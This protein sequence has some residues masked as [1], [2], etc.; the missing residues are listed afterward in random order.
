[1][2]TY[3]IPVEETFSF[4]RPV[5][6]KDLE[7]APGGPSKGQ[8]YIV[9]VAG[10]GWSGGAAKDIAWYDGAAWQFDT[11]AAG[12]L[13]WVVDEAKFYVFRGGVW[14]L[15]EEGNGDMLKSVY[16]IDDNGIVDKAETVD[17]GTSGNSST[18]AE[19]R[20]AV[21]NSH[22]QG[23]DQGLD[24]G[25]GNAVTAAEAKEAFDSR[26]IYDVDLGCILMDLT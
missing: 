26:G 19:V 6:D 1:M 15:L 11:P 14:A 3:R 23:T 10:G 21:D 24:T 18:A 4:Q 16:D 17:D 22:I 13:T 7:T 12:W 25:G 2:S 9:K 20:D 8:R 5:L